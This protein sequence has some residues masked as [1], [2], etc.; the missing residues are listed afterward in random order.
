MPVKRLAMV[1]VELAVG[2]AELAMMG[3]GGRW[4]TLP[5]EYRVFVGGCGPMGPMGPLEPPLE[6]IVVV[7]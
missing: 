5:G 6:G 3:P 1:L 2:R 4:D 7:E